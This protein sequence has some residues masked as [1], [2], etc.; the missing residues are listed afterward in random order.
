[1]YLA[2]LTR[3][4]WPIVGTYLTSYGGGLAPS[5]NPK[6]I[7]TFG[8]RV[9]GAGSWRFLAKLSRIRTTKNFDPIWATMLGGINPLAVAV[10]PGMGI[11]YVAGTTL[12]VR[13][14]TTPGAFRSYFTRRGPDGRL[15]ESRDGLLPDRMLAPGLPCFDSS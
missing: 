3:G 11:P 9:P 10:Q 4:G 5:G 6:M 7:Y 12:D 8:G 14:E 13:F 15:L 1:M 2:G